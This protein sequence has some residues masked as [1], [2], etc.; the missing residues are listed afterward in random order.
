MTNTF[1]TRTFWLDILDYL[2][3]H[4][5]YFEP[6]LFCHYILTEISGFV[7]QIVNH[8]DVQEISRAFVFMDLSTR[9]FN[10]HLSSV[11]SHIPGMIWDNIP[12][13]FHSSV[14]IALSMNRVLRRTLQEELFLTVSTQERDNR[15]FAHRVTKEAIRSLSWQI[16]VYWYLK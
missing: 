9:S 16:Q 7:Y 12:T 2:S 13:P 8:H 4:S 6:Q 14:I 5:L 10:F 1:S 3:R 11:F 15:R